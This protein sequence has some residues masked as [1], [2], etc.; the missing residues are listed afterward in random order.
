MHYVRA[1]EIIEEISNECEINANGNAIEWCQSIVK[2]VKIKQEVINFRAKKTRNAKGV[3]TTSEKQWLASIVVKSVF[4]NRTWPITSYTKINQSTQT[5][6]SSF[7][8][9]D[10]FFIFFAQPFIWPR[11][12]VFNKNTLHTHTHAGGR[13]NNMYEPVDCKVNCVLNQKPIRKIHSII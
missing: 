12:R 8:S 5:D 13:T 11:S 3:R 1:N 4:D 9:F 10:L 2:E 6:Y 7:P